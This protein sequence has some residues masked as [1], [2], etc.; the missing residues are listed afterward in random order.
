MRNVIRSLGAVLAACWVLLAPAAG[1]AQTPVPLEPASPEIEGARLDVYRVKLQLAAAETALR[2]VE[3]RRQVGT[4][5]IEEVQRAQ[6]TVA[7]LKAQL[8]QL[9]LVQTAQD[10]MALLQRPID[11]DLQQATVRQAA[12]ALGSASGVPITVDDAVTTEA[13]VTVRARRVPF[14]QVLEAVGSRLDVMFSPTPDRRGIRIG[15]WP[16]LEV[17][18][19]Q[20]K[21][22]SPFAP[23]SSDWDPLPTSRDFWR[24]GGRANRYVDLV[25]GLPA[26]GRRTATSRPAA[27]SDA[28]ETPGVPRE[29]VP[30]P[31]NAGAMLPGPASPSVGIDNGT[32]VVAEPGFREG[33]QGVWLTVYRLQGQELQ[34]VGAVFHRMATTA[35]PAAA[36]Q[37]RAVPKVTPAPSKPPAPKPPAATPRGK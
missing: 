28:V 8:E 13:R 12:Q 7:D 18:G 15:P 17:D 9:V 29:P 11:V 33:Q 24:T 3:T 25:T 35:G 4:A 31:A 10:R 6:A 30:A 1:L 32:I 20:E 34:K 19:K 27:A 14:A 2:A 26:A 36:P 23:W 37:L 22:R 21:F 5:T 16:T